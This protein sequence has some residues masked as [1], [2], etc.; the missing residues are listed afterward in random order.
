MADKQKETAMKKLQEGAHFHSSSDMNADMST[1]AADM[2]VLAVDKYIPTQNWEVRIICNFVRTTTTPTGTTAASTDND[3]VQMDRTEM[4]H[5]CFHCQLN[6][7]FSKES[8]FCISCQQNQKQ[9]AT[10]LLRL[11]ETSIYCCVV[12]CMYVVLTPNLL[13]YFLSLSSLAPLASYEH[14]AACRFIKEAMDRRFGPSWHVSVGEGF[15]FQI[16]HQQRQMLYM[17]HANV[18]VLIFKC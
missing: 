9:H 11:T 10:R 12:C 17:I 5:W 7:C 18:G 3:R 6:R 8:I 15:G 16:T 13:F 4:E 2:V 1:E 14:Q